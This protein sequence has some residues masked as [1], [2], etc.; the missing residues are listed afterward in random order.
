ME[1]SQRKGGKKVKGK[2]NALL[3]MTGRTMFYFVILLLLVLL[4]GFHDMSAGPFIYTE[5]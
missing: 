2:G 3:K 5:F 1:S 4:Y